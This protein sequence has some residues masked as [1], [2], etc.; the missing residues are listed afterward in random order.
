M[1][2]NK[3]WH[4]RLQQSDEARKKRQKRKRIKSLIF[5]GLLIV[6]IFNFFYP[7]YLKRMIYPYLF[8][9]RSDEQ[10]IISAEDY[11]HD[12]SAPEVTLNRKGKKFR[13]IPKTNYKVTARLGYIDH[14]DTLFNRFFRGQFQGDYINLVPRDLLLVIGDM[15]KPEIFDLFRFEHEER[16]GIVKCKGVIYRES[17]VSGI[18]ISEKKWQKSE[19]ANKTC[20]PH[21][22]TLLYNNYHPIP[23]NER[24]DKAL[25]MLLPGD[26]VQIE[27]TLV[28]VIMPDGGVL[29]TG[30]RKNQYHNMF[31]GGQKPGKCFIIYTTKITVNGFSYK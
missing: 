15:A 7:A 4:E 29:D 5:K 19:A 11:F 12:I 25:S 17:F 24:I 26:I 14:Y 22:N 28:D 30:T 3:I 6:L 13:L 18:G 16:L 31:T 1:T 21:I 27:G 8:G 9:Q 2:E 20:S 10:L 23:A